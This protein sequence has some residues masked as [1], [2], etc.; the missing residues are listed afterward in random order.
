M[1]RKA[2]PPI[3][4]QGSQSMA[5][6]IINRVEFDLLHTYF[7]TAYSVTRIKEIESDLQG[8]VIETE[9]GEHVGEAVD[10]VLFNMTGLE[11]RHIDYTEL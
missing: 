10:A 11:V 7:D 8:Y 1:G 2:S 9:P 5:K 4:N 3:Y 6:V